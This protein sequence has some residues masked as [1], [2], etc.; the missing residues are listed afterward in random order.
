MDEDVPT[1]FAHAPRILVLGDIHGDVGRLMR[2]LYGLQVVTPNFEWVADPPNT[3]IV[4]LGD[5]IDSASRGN[6]E[7]WETLP[8]LEVLQMMDRLDTLARPHG[9]RVI[10]LL[11]NHELMNVL[12]DFTYV[13]PESMAA[14]GDTRR[15]RFTPGG[16]LAL[17][18]SRRNVVVR[19]GEHLF[20]H[21]GILPRH[22][23]LV[24]GNLHRINAV[25]RKFLRGT[26]LAPEEGRILQDVILGESGILWT[27]VYLMYA[28]NNPEA[29]DTLLNSVLGALQCKAVYVGHNTVPQI[30]PIS[31][32]RCWFVDATFS[33]AYPD[34]KMSCLEITDTSYRVM[35]VTPQKVT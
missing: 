21:G 24:D 19:I 1:Y 20:C 23:H 30:V 22:L 18:L 16:D 25:C 8:D 6:A 15:E 29:M 34:A 33:R 14:T 28:A 4:Q 17:K 3:V 26:P 12:G 31:Q 9:G 10:S 32:G 11:G 7:K 5:Q 2:M 35:E 27:R 13:S